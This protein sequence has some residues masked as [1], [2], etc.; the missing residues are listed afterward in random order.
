MD[1]LNLRFGEF[2]Q[3]LE[4]LDTRIRERAFGR[5]AQF[6]REIVRPAFLTFE[7]QGAR[8]IAVSPCGLPQLKIWAAADDVVQGSGV[9]QAQPVIILQP[10]NDVF[11]F[12][13]FLLFRFRNELLW[14][15]SCFFFDIV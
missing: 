3:L 14:G 7:K 12:S 13:E 11:G 4:V 10:G 2:G 6:R 5:R 15:F 9:S 8:R 1:L